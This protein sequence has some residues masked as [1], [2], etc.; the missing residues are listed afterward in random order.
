MFI[1]KFARNDNKDHTSPQR[2][3]YTV[4]ILTRYHFTRYVQYEMC[5]VW[6]NLS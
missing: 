3:C 2:L 6:R 5:E 1:N 4:Y